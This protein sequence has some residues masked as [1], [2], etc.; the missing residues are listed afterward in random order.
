MIFLNVIGCAKNSLSVTKLSVL[1][2]DVCALT[3]KGLNNENTNAG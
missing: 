3:N 1:I 2:S